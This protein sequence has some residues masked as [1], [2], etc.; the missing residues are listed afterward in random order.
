MKTLKQLFSVVAICFALVIGF[1]SCNTDP[2]GTDDGANVVPFSIT[3]STGEAVWSET[4][5]Q[6]LVL[7]KLGVGTTGTVPYL[8]VSSSTY[9]TVSVDEASKEW[10]TVSPLGGPEPALTVTNVYLTLTPNEGEDRTGII[11]FT[12]LGKSYTVEVQQRGPL[13]NANESRLVFV[14]DNFGGKSLSENTV[15]E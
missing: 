8:E 4:D 1:A 6:P 11:T 15:T 7:N 14:S 9:W 10:L 13:S 5:P 12:Q 2:K 3:Y